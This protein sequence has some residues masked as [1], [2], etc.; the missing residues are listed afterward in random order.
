M[1][2]LADRVDRQAA[3]CETLGSPMYA[4]I[5]SRVA[6]DVRAGGPVGELVAPVADL[7]EEAAVPLRLMGGVHA[8]VLQGRA[9]E[10]AGTTRVWAVLP[11]TTTGCGAPFVRW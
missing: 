4:H 7:P 8:L 10:L 11:S 2:P 5:L 3:A 1:L 9:P 6:D